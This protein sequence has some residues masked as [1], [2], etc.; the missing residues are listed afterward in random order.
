[1]PGCEKNCAPCLHVCPRNGPANITTV[2]GFW[3]RW[4]LPPDAWTG[5]ARFKG[6]PTCSAQFRELGGSRCLSMCRSSTAAGHGLSPQVL[7]NSYGI[8]PVQ[9]APTASSL[10]SCFFV[11]A[12]NELSQF[13]RA[14]V[15]P[16]HVL[17][18]CL[19]RVE[20]LESHAPWQP[21]PHMHAVVNSRHVPPHGLTRCGH[22]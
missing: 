1:M 17:T 9:I 4:M 5:L 2:H 7:R 10:S 18:S 8:E 21:Q 15:Q 22:H 6:F 20:S 13:V 12:S 14:T 16:G 19:I 3:L 11:L